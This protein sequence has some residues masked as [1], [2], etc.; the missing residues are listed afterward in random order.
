MAPLKQK[1]DL[2]ELKVATDLIDR[3]CRISIPFGE[4]CDYDLI[5]DFNGRLHRVQVNTRVLTGGSSWFGAALIR[6]RTGRS[7][8]RSDTRL[9]RW[10]GLPSTTAPANAASTA[11]RASW[12]PMGVPP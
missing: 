10:T 11:H 12:V 4:D 9:Q 6:S 3:G 7:A 1:G 2:A 8:P 5:A